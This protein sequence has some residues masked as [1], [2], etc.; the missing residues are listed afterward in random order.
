MARGDTA[1]N[2]AAGSVA[3]IESLLRVWRPLA[4]DPPS[5]F[6]LD[7]GKARA[8]AQALVDDLDTLRDSLLLLSG[9]IVIGGVDA[10]R[11]VRRKAAE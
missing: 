6:E 7:V 10:I 9:V 8:M 1:L 11:V 3:R 2:L 5:C 4:G